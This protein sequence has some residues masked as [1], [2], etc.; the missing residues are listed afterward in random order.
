MHTVFEPNKIPYRVDQV[1]MPDS[2]P[3]G[4]HL[5]AISISKGQ[6]WYITQRVNLSKPDDQPVMATLYVGVDI[7][8]PE[9]LTQMLL[10]F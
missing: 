5:C 9:L 3:L 7:P 10:V 6:S 8:P 1:P 4:S 2:I